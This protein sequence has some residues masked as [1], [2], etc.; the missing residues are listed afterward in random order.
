MPTTN[1][2]GLIALP[3]F[4]AIWAMLSVYLFKEWP[5]ACFS[6]LSINIVL[7]ASCILLGWHYPLD[8]LGAFVT[9]GVSFY[10]LQYYKKGFAIANTSR[11]KRQ[12]SDSDV[13]P[14]TN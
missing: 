1:E 13:H 11:I 7:V 12:R 2:G 10:A 8:I 14:T 3:S 9:L 5:V 4:H 6:L